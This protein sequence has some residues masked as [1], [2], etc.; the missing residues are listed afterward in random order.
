MTFRDRLKK[1]MQTESTSVEAKSGGAGSQC[2]PGM[3]RHPDAYGG[4]CHS[5]Q[6]K[7][8]REQVGPNQTPNSQIKKTVKQLKVD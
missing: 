5:V 2:G 1:R 7:H 8:T 6:Q 3:H 4:K